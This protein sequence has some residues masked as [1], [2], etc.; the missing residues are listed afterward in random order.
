MATSVP[1]ESKDALALTSA[2]QELVLI[3]F[4]HGFKGTDS[5]FGEFPNRLENVLGGTVPGLK[6][7]CIVFPAYEVSGEPSTMQSAR[8]PELHLNRPRANWSVCISRIE[9]VL[10]TSMQD[11][12][13]I[14]FADWLTTTTV[15]REVATGLGSGSA[16]I[17]LCGHR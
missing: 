13:V 8:R 11:K 12:A 10:S 7:E 3:I 1:P 5:T 2:V 16:K 17:V 4:I 6:A 14:K 15:E 9:N